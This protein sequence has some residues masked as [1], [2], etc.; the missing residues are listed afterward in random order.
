VSSAKFL[1]HASQIKYKNKF[2]YKITQDKNPNG[3]INKFHREF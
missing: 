3:S 1:N 2:L